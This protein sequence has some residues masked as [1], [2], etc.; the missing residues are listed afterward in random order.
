FRDV[1]N[2]LKEKNGFYYEVLEDLAD[3]LSISLSKKNID[4]SIEIYKEI[5]KYKE[6]KFGP[7]SSSLIGT[8]T[9]LSDLLCTSNKNDEGLQLLLSK[10]KIFENKFS[11]LH[12][13]VFDLKQPLIEIYPSLAV[14]N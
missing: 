3:L 9:Q 7:V 1:L 14:P 12:K 11:P 8:V 13:F 6:K 5:L 4:E 10:I 2:K